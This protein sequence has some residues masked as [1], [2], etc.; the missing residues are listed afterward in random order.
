M[1]DQDHSIQGGDY[2]KGKTIPFVCYSMNYKTVEAAEIISAVERMD[3]K[4]WIS[5]HTL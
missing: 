4:R 1:N 5:I 3:A 2:Q